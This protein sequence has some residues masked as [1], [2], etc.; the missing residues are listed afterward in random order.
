MEKKDQERLSTEVGCHDGNPR[1]PES[2][3]FLGWR[4]RRE[5]YPESSQNKRDP[6]EP[7][8]VVPKQGSHHPEG[9]PL[10]L[11][12]FYVRL[13]QQIA[14]LLT[15][16]SEVYISNT[17]LLLPVPTPGW[18]LAKKLR[19]KPRT[20]LLFNPTASKKRNLSDS[21][22]LSDF[23]SH[24]AIVNGRTWIWTRIYLAIMPNTLFIMLVD[25]KKWKAFE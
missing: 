12:L 20:N 15:I 14:F 24:R 6:W 9:V 17:L 7:K 2:L 21:E 1:H 8:T 19:V 10:G 25:F 18:S 16:S 22:N 4:G 23:S 3:A 5:R 13:I 11:L